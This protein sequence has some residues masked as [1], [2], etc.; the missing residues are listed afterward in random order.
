MTVLEYTYAGFLPWSLIWGAPYIGSLV[1]ALLWLAGYRRDLVYGVIS[2][3]SIAVSAIISSIAAFQVFSEGPIYSL[4]AGEWFPWL[5]VTVGTFIDG[6]GAVMALV[7]GWIS[8]LIGIYS[9]KYMEGDT[10]Y[11]RYFFFFTFFV[12]S[13]QLL[14]LADNLVLLF[15]GWEGTGIASYAL[16]GHWYSD[17]EKAWVGRPGRRALGRQMWFEPSHSAVRA[18]LFTRIGDLGLLVGIAYLFLVAGTIS[19]PELAS[20]P[21][22]WISELAARGILP[23]LL[24]I[25]TLGA[26]AKSAQFPF[27][28]WLV[29]AMTGPTPVSALIHAAT[30]V[31]AGVYFVLRFAPI[32]IAGG[33]ALGSNVLVV[34]GLRDYFMMLGVLGAV[35]AFMLATMAIV[36]DEVKL[37]MAYSTASQIG[38]MF[39]GV[40]AG[41]LLMQELE[42]AA[43]GVFSGL[44]HLVS[45]AVFKAALFLIAGWLIH[46]AHSRFLDPMGGYYRYMKATGIAL[47]L[48][49]LSLAGIP[50]FSGFFSKE[51]VLK[52]VSEAHVPVLLA[53]GLIGAM[54]T[55]AYTL[56]LILRVLH[57]KPVAGADHGETRP[58]EAP[59]LMLVPY[60]VLSVAS[61]V[62]GLFW[63][64]LSE[65]YSRAAE[66]TLSLGRFADL[67]F[68]LSSEALVATSLI[69]IGA[70]APYFVYYLSGI[71]TRRLIERGLLARLHGFLYDRWYINS[72]YYM[73]FVD[74]SSRI[75]NALGRLDTAIDK[76]Y[77][78]LIPGAVSSLADS[79][80]SLHRGRTDYYLALYLGSTALAFLLALMEWG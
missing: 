44:A 16:I 43:G 7:V 11:A 76:L 64:L 31:K 71:D 9:I 60:L 42:K 66:L 80:R 29:T 36:S 41:G 17:E 70:F 50:P 3:L 58:G 12:A 10:G 8:L 18:V 33:I 74:G 49:G 34:E 4:A 79:V 28:E 78:S 51:S 69:L 14:V 59:R 62:M 39:L 6:L 15:V 1:I 55:A 68:K 30:M 54:L 35:T 46:V 37:I 65:A 32:L 25:F 23:L 77:H 27:H 48:S 61:L 38:Y 20:R 19:I 56:R 73:V 75:I 22:F 67:A 13:M 53:L 72:L 24:T 47:W 45:H 26:L 57:L 2:A 63:G 21:D 52:Y 40:A 5:G